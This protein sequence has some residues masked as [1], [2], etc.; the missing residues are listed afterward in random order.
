MRLLDRYLLR[1]LLTPLAYCL[2]GFL[3]FYVAF[4]L[5]FHIAQFQEARLTPFD[6][7]K[8]YAATVPEVLAEQVI[9]V[10][11]L[12]A[13]LYALTNHS[14]HHELIAMRAAGV[15]V[16][17]LA[18]PYLAVGAVLG[19]VVLVIN[20]TLSPGADE[21]ARE[22]LLLRKIG[23]KSRVVTGRIHF[24]SDDSVRDWV[25]DGG[26]NRLTGELLQPQVRWTSQQPGFPRQILA[27]SAQFRDGQWVFADADVWVWD[28]DQST[29]S[30][31]FKIAL[32]ES[33]EWIR[34]EIDCKALAQ[35][36]NG[37]AKRPQLSIAELVSY[38]RFHP[39]LSPEQS[40]VY[41]TQLQ[42]R[43]AE[44]FT[45]MAVALIAFPFGARSGRHNVFVGV[46]SSI[47]ICFTY[48]IVQRITFGLGTAGDLPPVLAAWLPNIVFGGAGLVLMTRL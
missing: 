32:P 14:R 3:I 18:A 26:M 10:S 5:I 15:G 35:D 20:E 36:R 29:I 2:C 43:I 38:L 21:R 22:I 28:K 16:W 41:Y 42:G 37:A 39:H 46:A 24:R 17:R 6:V 9:P 48:F 19:G 25:I 7:V 45:C 34:T 33:P 1:E 27:A 4:D 30:P 8:Y 13:M 40:P 44:P 11:L 12:L 47:F 31:E 23:P